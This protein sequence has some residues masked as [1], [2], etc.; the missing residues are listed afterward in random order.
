MKII[1]CGAGEVG[2]H[3][4][5]ELGRV[6]HSI[7]VIDLETEKLRTLEESMDIATL[8]GNCADAEILVQAGGQDADLVL[9]ATNNDEV[10]LLTAT[11]AKGLGAKKVIARVH[12]SAFFEQRGFHQYFLHPS[13]YLLERLK[14]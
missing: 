10:N 11:V 6:G 12:H 5:E 4:A 14:L 8:H 9:A 13:L 7:R 1:I 2:S 3:A